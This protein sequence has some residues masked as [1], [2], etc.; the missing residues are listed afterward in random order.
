MDSISK[1]YYGIKTYLNRKQTLDFLETL[2]RGRD[3]VVE[4]RDLPGAYFT[5]FVGPLV[6]K[7][8]KSSKFSKFKVLLTNT[9]GPMP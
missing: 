5:D 3:F 2:Q 9:I 4:F 7:E 6:D 8:T 1:E